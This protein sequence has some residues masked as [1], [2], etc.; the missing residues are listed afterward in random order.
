M[1]FSCILCIKIMFMGFTYMLCYIVGISIINKRS[2]LYFHKICIRISPPL[3]I[4]IQNFFLDCIT[5]ASPSTF[6]I[7]ILI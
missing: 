1:H 7:C 3:C 5:A 4:S 6:Q 2:Y